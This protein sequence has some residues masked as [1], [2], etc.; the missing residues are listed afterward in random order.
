M[1]NL[2][3]CTTAHNFPRAFFSRPGALMEFAPE[4]RQYEVA[5][6]AFAK[7]SSRAGIRAS[8]AAARR[9]G[10]K[11]T[12]AAAREAAVDAVARE[13]CCARL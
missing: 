7:E 3:H 10:F 4:R 13:P 2:A 1:I 12:A 11:V 6:E 9:Y 5:I 8:I